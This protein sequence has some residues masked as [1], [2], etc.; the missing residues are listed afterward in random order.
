MLGVIMAMLSLNS[1][2][3]DL[4]TTAGKIIGD[5][6]LTHITEDGW[7]WYYNEDGTQTD[8][9][10]YS[11]SYDVTPE[12]EDWVVFRIT[13]LAMSVIDTGNEEVRF[14]L[15]IPFPYSLKGNKLSSLLLEADHTNVVTVSF[16]DDDTMIFYLNDT[17][18]MEDGNGYENYEQWAT[19]RRVK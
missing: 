18:Y 3:P 10:T 14:L 11:D 6:E 19:Y 4:E 13:S 2:T 7:W 5:W 12:N 16:E 1:C 17:G 9:Y 15:N 8:T